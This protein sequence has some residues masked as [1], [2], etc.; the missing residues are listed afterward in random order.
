[1]LT[2]IFDNIY[3]K[4]EIK[5]KKKDLLTLVKEVITEL[6]R[7]TYVNAADKMR[8]KGQK[9]RANK[10]IMHGFD[11]DTFL[12]KKFEFDGSTIQDIESDGEDITIKTENWNYWTYM[13]RY[14]N[15]VYT[16]GRHQN[17]DDIVLTRRDSRLLSKIAFKLNPNTQYK[18]GTGNFKI[19]D[20]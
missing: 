10:L 3:I 11:F 2:I 9:K 7:S 20:Y 15:W 18:N 13:S 14:D 8:D 4:N 16:D 5:M 17:F 12:G 6:D 1:M 19:K